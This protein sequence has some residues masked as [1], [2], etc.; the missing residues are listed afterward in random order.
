MAFL[1]VGTKVSIQGVD[2]FGFVHQVIY[3]CD[4]K[5]TLVNI[6]LYRT[7]LIYSPP[8]MILICA[9]DCLPFEFKKS[10]AK[11]IYATGEDSQWAHAMMAG[12]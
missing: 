12:H 7:D 8:E 11:R 6:E 1:K 10:T 9:E 2:G 4:S 5:K 3:A